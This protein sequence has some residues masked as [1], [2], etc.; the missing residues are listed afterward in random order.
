VE[1]NV[2]WNTFQME[3]DKN[4]E[5]T[6]WTNNDNIEDTIKL[7]TNLIIN[8]ASDVF[9]LTSYFGKIMVEC[10]KPSN[11]QYGKKLPLTNTN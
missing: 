6:S 8:T 9:E 1:K 7:F 2:D 5:S 4:I 3:I 10:Q 11:K